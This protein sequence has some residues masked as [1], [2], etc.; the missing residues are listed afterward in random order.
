M[1]YSGNIFGSE[2]YRGTGIRAVSGVTVT[3]TVLSLFSVAAAIYVVANFGEL[4]AEI[5]IWTA[6]FLSSGFPVLVVIV[7]V[8]YFVMRLRW[9]IRSHF[10]RW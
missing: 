5:A 8:T 2:S 10:W 1:R 9:K 7:A 6:N 4:T 3:T